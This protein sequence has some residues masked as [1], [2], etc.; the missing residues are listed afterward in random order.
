MPGAPKNAIQENSGDQGETP[1]NSASHHGLQ[2]L[3]ERHI[4]FYKK[5]YTN[6]IILAPLI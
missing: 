5:K 1:H 4:Y 3:L 2:C 6:E